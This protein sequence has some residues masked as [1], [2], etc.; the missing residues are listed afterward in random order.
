MSILQLQCVI[1]YLAIGRYR[2]CSRTIICSILIIR[3]DKFPAAPTKIFS[4][5]IFVTYKLRMSS[6]FV[7][8]F[9][10]NRSQ[11][12][13]L[14]ELWIGSINYNMT[15]RP[16]FLSFFIIDRFEL[17][18]HYISY[19]KLFWKISYHKDSLLKGV[20]NSCWTSRRSNSHHL[21]AVRQETVHVT[22]S[23]TGP[24]EWKIRDMNA[25]GYVRFGTLGLQFI[26]PNVFK[27]DNSLICLE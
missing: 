24:A 6:E 15:W 22:N 2:Y 9:D 12:I 11:N 8:N 1:F 7:L 4:K 23:A 14:N 26:S 27:K 17:S 21:K 3:R 5:N 25:T 16:D 13:S 20:P 19:W 10:G 18:S